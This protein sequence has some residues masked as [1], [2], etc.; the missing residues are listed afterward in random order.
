MFKIVEN[1][2][3]ETLRVRPIFRTQRE[4]AADTTIGPGIHIKKGII[5]TKKAVF[6]TYFVT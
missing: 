6:Q 4:A 3:M 2:L 1:V 5:G